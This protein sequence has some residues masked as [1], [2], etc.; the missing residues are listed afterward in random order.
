[1]SPDKILDRIGDLNPQL[2]RELKGRLTGSSLTATL[3][4]SVLIQIVIGLFLFGDRSFKERFYYDIFQCLNWLMPICLIIGGIYTLISDLNQEEKRGTL[5]AIKL[6]PQSG[7]SIFLGKI[8]G[9]PSLVY[10]AVLSIVP[11]HLVLAVVNGANLGLILT[12]YC[13]IGVTTY[14]FL[15]LTILYIL[16]GGKF[17]ILLSVLA[18][19]PVSS[20]VGIYN[21]YLDSAVSH[22]EWINNSPPLF[23]W[24]Y[25]PVVNNIWLFYCWVCGIFLVISHWLWQ[26]IERKYINPAGK[27]L[28]KEHSYWINVSFQFWLIGFAL[29]LV[30]EAVDFNS[31]ALTLTIFYSIGTVWVICLIPIILPSQR[32]MQEWSYTWH[33]QFKDRHFQS[34]NQDLIQNLIWHDRS[35]SVLAMAINLAISAIVWGLCVIAFVHDL[36]LLIKFISGIALAS[37]LTLIYTVAINFTCLR[38]PLKGA[39]VAAPIFLM[40]FSPIMFGSLAAMNAVNQDL[41]FGLLLFSPLFWLGIAKLSLPSIGIAFI[42]QLG[43]LVGLT[44]LLQQRL[45]TIGASTTQMFDRQRLPPERTSI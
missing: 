5:N 20:F 38:S 41:G 1:M 45:Q 24:F 32:M 7:R 9:V 28:T 8:L 12:W 40:S 36:E 6:S 44:K 39:G 4:G 30:T 14:L 16:H 10:L 35:P 3:I 25:L 37:I 22:K 21:H 11:M 2:F 29:P 17:A 31:S 23:S 15:S 43:I 27:I 42:A 33:K 26:A 13:T 34:W 18:L 19:K